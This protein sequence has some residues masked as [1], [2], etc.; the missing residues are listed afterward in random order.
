MVEPVTENNV[1]LMLRA[2]PASDLAER[3]LEEMIEGWRNQQLARNLSFGTIAGREAEVR[4]FVN[5]AGEY[6]WHWSAQLLDEWLGDQRSVHHFRQSTIRAKAVSV[7][8][9]CDYLVDPAYAWPEECWERFGTHPVQV[10]HDWNTAV[11]V[12]ASEGRAGLRAFTVEELQA[13]FDCADELVGLARERGRKGWLS[14]YRDATMFKITYAWGLRRHEVSMLEMEDFG[15]NPQAP[16]FGRFGI[17][18]VRHGKAMRGSA[19]KQRSVL[20][21]FGWA[22]ECL[23]DWTS[24]FRP[25][26][27]R[28]GTSVLWPT[29][30]GGRLGETRMNEHFATV[31]RELGFSSELTFHS[32]RRSYVTHLIEDGFDPRFVQEQVGHEHASTTSIYTCVSSDFRTRSL[33]AALDRAIGPLGLDTGL[34]RQP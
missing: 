20:S 31:R 13:F 2:A 21:V 17:L 12:Q 10:C 8:M 25:L 11:H 4:R 34:R 33:R 22:A 30:R 27:A 19:P 29:E 1:V 15:T 5:Q 3:T 18:Y 23:A 14:S 24:E 26:M 9:F 6:P 7:R 32:F 16:E 28:D